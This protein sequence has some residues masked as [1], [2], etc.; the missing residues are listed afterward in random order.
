MT[1]FDV[2]IIGSG[3]AG[4]TA[5]IYMLRA[6]YSTCIISGPQEG[7]QLMITST[8]ENFPGFE[9]ISGPD[10]MDRFKQQV[11]NL[12]AT[13]IQDIIID[14]DFS[15]R[16]KICVGESGKSYFA[17]AVI[18]ATGA[19]AKWLCV[20]GE[21]EYNGRGVSACATCDGF[22]F[23]NKDVVVVGGGNTAVQEAIYLTK[24]AKSVTLIHRRDKFRAE[25]IT[26]KKLLA[27]ESITILYNSVIIEIIGNQSRVTSVKLGS[28][29]DDVQKIIPT[30][31]VFV[32]IG[33]SP[34]SEIFKN[35]IDLNEN[36]YILCKNSSTETS[37]LGVFA[38]GDVCDETY[39]QAITSA[40][41]GCMAAIDAI[42]Y[43]GLLNIV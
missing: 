2:I 32:A 17:N 6:G 30:D 31:G 42:S 5:A 34:A 26:V 22:F 14:V 38:C 41:Q 16:L 3:P 20:K 13:V 8:I 10:L 23:K 29:V 21:R 18:I 7:G 40:G 28:T 12:G 27:N 24:F 43:L 11:V 15:D 9:N 19:K 33:H 4:Y 36:G 37:V 35:K 1:K 25:N 39:R